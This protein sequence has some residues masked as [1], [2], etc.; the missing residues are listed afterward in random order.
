METGKQYKSTKNENSSDP[1]VTTSPTCRRKGKGQDN[2]WKSQPKFCQIDGGL[3]E[4]KK[5][6]EMHTYS[7]IVE[8]K[9]ENISAAIEV[10]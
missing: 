5:A 10:T 8:K 7:A 4:V 6:L 2:M 1:V 9:I 3:A